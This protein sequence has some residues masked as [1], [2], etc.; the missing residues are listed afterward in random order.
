VCAVLISRVARDALGTE[1]A[2][3]H[4]THLS[5]PCVL[6]AH[7]VHPSLWLGVGETLGGHELG[8]G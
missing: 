2:D 8:W 4:R 5:T 1:S 3:P 7:L 6:L